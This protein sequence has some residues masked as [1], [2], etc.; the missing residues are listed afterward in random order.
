MKKRKK[1][2]LLILCLLLWSQFVRAEEEAERIL[3]QAAFAYQKLDTYRDNFTAVLTIPATFSEM[4]L[5]VMVAFKRPNKIIVESKGPMGK[6]IICSDGKNM[7][8]Y[9]SLLNAYRKEKAQRKLPVKKN[10]D[11]MIASAVKSSIC[12]DLILSE[13]PYQT[14]MEGVKTAKLLGSEE[15]YGRPTYLI[16]M[17]QETEGPFGEERVPSRLQLWIEKENY[18]ILKSKI[19]LEVIVPGSKEKSLIIVTEEHPGMKVNEEIADFI[20]TFT[21]PLGARLVKKFDQQ[22]EK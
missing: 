19:Y 11:P 1:I 15:I 14:L 17:E 7:W 13:D 3:K 8:T 20:F 10:L 5:S 9:S 22:K 2:V 16:E 6:D 18:L 12:L 21:P 4:P